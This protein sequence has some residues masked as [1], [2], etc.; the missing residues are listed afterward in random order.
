MA[1]KQ[2]AD[3]AAPSSALLE[4]AGQLLALG[5]LF[6]S[7][8][9]GDGAIA[10]I[11]GEAGAGKSALVRAFL[12]SVPEARTL[13]G[14]CDGVSTPRPLGPVHDMA[15]SLGPDVAT[16]LEGDG[17]AR[18]RL[19]DIFHAKL[20]EGPATIVVIED[21]HWGDEAT[22]DLLRHVGRRV[23][24]ISALVVATYRDDE[25]GPF[26]ALQ[27]VLGDLATTRATHRIAVPPLSR[28]AVRAMVADHPA[29]P[30]AIYE[31][32][33][34][35]AFFVEE[36]LAGGDAVVPATVRDAVRA[37]VARLAPRARRALEAAAVLGARSKAWLLA[38]VAAEDALGIDD[39]I[40]AGLLVQHGDEA[41]F[42]HELTRFAVV[43]DLPVI[44]RVGFHRRALAFLER[45][46]AVD[47]AQLAYHAEGAADGPAVVRYA[48][49]AARRAAALS[50][51]SVAIA[52]FQRALRFF[53]RLA[54]RERADVLETMAYE[55]FLTNRLDDAYEARHAAITL[56]KELGDALRLGDDYRYL[57]RVAWFRGIGQEAWDAAREAIRILEPLGEGRELAMA[58]GNMS[59]LHMI[60]QDRREAV[61]WGE[62]A[63]ELGRQLDDPEVIAYTLNN[64]GSAELATGEEAG[65]DKLLESLRIAKEH[66][67]QEHIDRALF[68]LGES[69]L[70]RHEYA[71]AE[72]YLQE[73]LEYTLSCDLERC[74]LLADAGRALVR[75]ELGEW[76][77][78][79][80]IA[81]QVVEHP[82]VSPHGSLIAQCVLARLRFRRAEPGGEE[83]LGEASRSAS[84]SGELARLSVTAATRAEAAWLDGRTAEAAA[85]AA[86]VYPMALERDDP[87]V[88][89]ELAVWQWRAGD[90]REVPENAA[91]PYRLEMLGDAL[92]A[93]A[94]WE[95]RGNP[96]QAAVCRAASD[97]VDDLLAARATLLEL[98]ATAT[99]RLVAERLRARGASVPRGPRAATRANLAHLTDRE[100]EIAE[101]MAAGMTNRE[102]ADRLVISEKTVGHHVSAVLAKLGVS[103]RAQVAT[104]L[105]EHRPVPR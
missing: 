24:N 101:L 97:N 32:T 27:V 85:A 83:L 58:W 65:R 49:E 79:E 56:R 68:N 47:A 1:L 14:V 4:R 20:S 91:E 10:F 104:A 2:R 53:E 28:E 87:W 92:G 61:A 80:H 78:A 39:C 66:A 60:A 105:L 51:H 45:S 43:Q 22:F 36:L 59:H 64:I 63:L 41:A 99:A 94:A 86:E 57:S 74:Q 76:D 81:R 73:C 25:L 40:T 23:E 19:F 82:R 11:S 5:D 38:A 12:E 15:P 13:I 29:D 17:V 37:R 48:G 88:I 7:A 21:L 31:L 44:R 9:R 70:A 33:G 55:M 18:R 71:S 96:Y 50:A 46:G 95:L 75:L 34:G 93:A 103:R 84:L 98:G 42:R 100:A 30:D 89:G 77:K 90:L 72:R 16:L 52:Q 67:M 62:R 69:D 6:D 102:I 3:G 35:N 54:P 26:D 8:R